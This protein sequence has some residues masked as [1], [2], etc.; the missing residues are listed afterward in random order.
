MIRAA[1]RRLR[2]L[3]T[4]QVAGPIVAYALTAMFVA[5]VVQAFVA[6]QQAYDSQQASRAAAVRRIDL[7]Q[8]QINDLQDRLRH[9]KTTDA[10]QRGRMQDAIAALAEQIRQ[11]G[12][13]PVTDGGPSSTSTRPSP[14]ATGPPPRPQPTGHPHHPQPTH[15][16]PPPPSPSPSSTPCDLGQALQHP[17]RCL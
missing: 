2:G 13:Q 9:V 17:L 8:H 11:L 4:W 7:L 16:P 5:T 14:A 6:R 15:T 1:L 10:R 3:A 12:G